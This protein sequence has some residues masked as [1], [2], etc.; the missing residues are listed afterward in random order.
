MIEKFGGGAMHN[1]GI[2][3]NLSKD[4]GLKVTDS[5]I[6]W[7]EEHDGRIMLP[8]KVSNMLD[9]P[10]YSYSTDEIYQKSDFVIVLGG[11]GT[12]LG[13]ARAAARYQTPLLGVNMGRLGFLAEVELKELY[14]SLEAVFSG[15]IEIEKR[16][17]LQAV[18]GSGTRHLKHYALNDIVLAR[19]TL[20]RIISLNV[21]IDDDYV[22]TVEGD[23]LIIATPTGSTAYSLSAGGPIIDPK[24]SVITLTPICP[25]S[26]SNRSM[27]ISDDEVVKVELAEGS[28]DTYFT[29]DGQEGFKIEGGENITIKKAPYMTNLVKVLNSNFYGVLRNKLTE[30]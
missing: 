2:I 6:K 25:H 5:I 14:K 24:L 7:V 12:I 18:K 28:G 9:L 11:D 26:F 13:A 15:P 23:G 21:Y 27:V 16:L 19:R 29:I 1:V 17:M 30:K 4:K 3:I 22:T 10:N 20:S 8:D